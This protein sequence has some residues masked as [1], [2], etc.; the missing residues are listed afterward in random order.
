MGIESLKV[1]ISQKIDFQ[2]A[3]KTKAKKRVRFRNR[4]ELKGEIYETVQIKTR[5]GKQSK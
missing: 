3:A 1:I 5:F 4:S 2:K